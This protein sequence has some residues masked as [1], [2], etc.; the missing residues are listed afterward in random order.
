MHDIQVR[1]SGRFIDLV[2][3][4][5]WEYAS[6]VHRSGVAVIV[7]VTD[8][9]ELILVEQYRI[10]VQASVIELPAGLIGD[11]PEHANESGLDAA[12]RELE[13]E[14]GFRAADMDMLIH[15]PTTAGLA[16]EMATFYLAGSLQRIHAGGGD[17]SEQILVHVIPLSGIDGWLDDQAAAGKLLDPKIYSALYWLHRRDIDVHRKQL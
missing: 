15:C 10:P 4:D 9:R 2:E 14:T 12:V 6:R 17:S 16:D 3:R 1:Y 8:A 7:A 13:E 11:S 5:N